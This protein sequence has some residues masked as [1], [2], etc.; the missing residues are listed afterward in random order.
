MASKSIKMALADM[1]EDL[2]KQDFDKFRHHLLDR[3][4][5]PRVRRN[6]VE[7]KNFLDIADVLVSTFTETKALEVALEILRQMGC[8][9]DA[10]RLADDVKV[11]G[12]SSAKPGPSE[13]KH[14]VDK[15]KVELIK[16]VSNIGPILDELWDH[17]VLQQEVYDKIRAL[18]TNQQKM[19]ELFA[20][21][22]RASGACKDVFYQLLESNEPYL[23]KDLK[24]K[25]D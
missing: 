25:D 23:I 9:G 17:D 3:R 12:G 20:G 4:Q 15:H 13:T 11:A 1:L 10:D 19:R 6:R 22:L 14:F 16:R 2:S 18:S 21:P 24:M 7:G 8:N 5:E